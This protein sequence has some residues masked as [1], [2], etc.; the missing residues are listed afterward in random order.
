MKLYQFKRNQVLPIEIQEAWDFFSSPVNLKEITPDSMGFDIIS[1]FE[2]EKMYPGLILEYIIRPLLN[3][4]VHWVTEI[5]QVKEPFYFVDE[6]R[7]GPYKFWHHQHHFKETPEGVEVR[8]I[9][10]YSLPFGFFADLMHPLIVEPRL[11]K[12]FDYR[13]E[14]LE[15]KFV[16]DG[17][18]ILV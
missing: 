2:G 6:Q 5:T 12:I 11:K 14:K 8:D 13:S 4:P 10:N 9:V 3:I 17:E 1:D 15:N 16:D 18:R 7:F